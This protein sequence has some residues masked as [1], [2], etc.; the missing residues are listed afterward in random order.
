MCLVSC[1]S[2]SESE[3]ATHGSEVSQNEPMHR[4]WT[5]E[6]ADRILSLAAQEEGFVYSTRLITTTGQNLLR[7]AKYWPTWWRNNCASRGKFERLPKSIPWYGCS[8]LLGGVFGSSEDGL[9]TFT[10]RN[11]LENLNLKLYLHP[12]VATPA[13]DSV[14]EQYLKAT[15][16]ASHPS[17]FFFGT[18]PQTEDGNGYLIKVD[19]NLRRLLLFPDKVTHLYVPCTRQRCDGYLNF[20]V[21]AN[22]KFVTVFQGSSLAVLLA[23]IQ[24]MLTA[25]NVDIHEFVENLNY[26]ERL[27]P[28]NPVCVLTMHAFLRQTAEKNS[29]VP[30]NA[31]TGRGNGVRAFYL[32]RA[33]GGKGSGGGGGHGSQSLYHDFTTSVTHTERTIDGTRDH[34]FV[35]SRAL[36]VKNNE[37]PKTLMARFMA[38]EMPQ[39]YLALWEAVKNFAATRA[40]CKTSTVYEV[41]GEIVPLTKP[42]C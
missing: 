32:Y 26:F 3:A 42:K 36:F 34:N 39:K 15:T 33:S 24:R 35:Y 29:L 22:A 9:A 17:A 20:G 25:A 12:A 30:F 18:V 23:A 41:D 40:E 21:D 8:G 27:T 6:E 14:R 28:S 7:Y 11:G 19:D 2:F 13:P 1:N 5:V 10:L 4:Q 38:T 16:L 31:N 37:D